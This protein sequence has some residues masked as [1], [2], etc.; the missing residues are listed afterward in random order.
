MVAYAGVHVLH[1][2]CNNILPDMDNGNVDI[3]DNLVETGKKLRKKKTR[4]SES[5][6][7]DESQLNGADSQ[8][9]A[10]GIAT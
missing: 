4:R 5:A 9:S 6:P 8:G 10:G 7:Q 3:N 1:D 2:E